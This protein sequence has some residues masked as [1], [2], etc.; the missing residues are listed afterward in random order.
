MISKK[1]IRHYIKRTNKYINY[2]VGDWVETCNMLPGIVQEIHNYYDPRKT[3]QCMVEDVIIFYPHYAINN[4]E[5]KGGSS[6]SITCCGVHQ[7][8]PEYAK[9]LFSLGYDKLTNM[10]VE[11]KWED[12]EIS[13]CDF[14]KKEYNKLSDK[15]KLN[16]IELF[17]I[18][19]DYSRKIKNIK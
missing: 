1:D 2:S 14:V 11:S 16:G 18:G 12:N 5:Y 8:S 9:M 6:C 19:E 3:M 15:E 17:N 7:I 13:W 10:W 4:P